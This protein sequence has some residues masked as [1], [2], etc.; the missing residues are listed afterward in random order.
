MTRSNIARGV[1]IRAVLW[2][3][4]FIITRCESGCGVK[5]KFTSFVCIAF[6]RITS[7]CKSAG[8]NLALRLRSFVRAVAL[9]ALSAKDCASIVMP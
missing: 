9:V 3:R 4:E 6:R 8:L 7:C 1:S 2:R 5:F